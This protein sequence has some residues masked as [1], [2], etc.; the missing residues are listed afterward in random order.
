MVF[1]VPF[2]ETTSSCAARRG[3]H[4]LKQEND[5][6]ETFKHKAEQ[7]GHK[8]AETATKVGH[9][10][11][12][13]VEEV[14]DWAKQ[15]AHQVGNRIGEA[16][17]KAEHKVKETFGEGGAQAEWSADI[18]EHMDVIGSCGNKLGKVD[19]VEG[20]KIK[21][22]KNDSPVGLHHFIPMDWVERVDE[23][24]YLNKSCGEAAREW[25]SE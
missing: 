18:R 11:G 22:T 5:M 13:K 9:R 20:S 7:A 17:Q 15:K 10:V 8:I 2:C 19:H 3:I 23:C 25:Q 6:A 21:L 4:E 12:E 16:T 14:T 24:V 1:A